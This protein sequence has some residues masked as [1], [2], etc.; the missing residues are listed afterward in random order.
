[1]FDFGRGS[2]LDSS[3]ELIALP[4]TIAIFT[5]IASFK[6]LSLGGTRLKY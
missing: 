1:M 4:R 3:E 2:A 5:G 6:E